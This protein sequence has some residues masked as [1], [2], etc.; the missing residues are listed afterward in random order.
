MTTPPLKAARSSLLRIFRVVGL[1]LRD[2]QSSTTQISTSRDI[3]TLTTSLQQNTDHNDCHLTH[4]DPS[5]REVNIDFLSHDCTETFSPL[6]SHLIRDAK[7]RRP[8][9][10]SSAS[11]NTSDPT[12]ATKTKFAA[13]GGSE[14][15]AIPFTEADSLISKK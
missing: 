14:L 12:T 15:L 4:L 5:K 1:P 2:S 10:L 6:R 9:A 7:H 13:T 11:V 8:K 3:S